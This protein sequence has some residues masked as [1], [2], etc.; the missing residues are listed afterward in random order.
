MVGVPTLCIGKLKVLLGEDLNIEHVILPCEVSAFIVFK[1]L[2]E[3]ISVEITFMLAACT[4][5]GPEK[6]ELG[7]IALNGFPLP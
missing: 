5:K 1:N 2:T 3:T 7:S 4:K 6:L